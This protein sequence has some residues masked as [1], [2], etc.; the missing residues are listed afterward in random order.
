MGNAPEGSTQCEFGV[1][2][3][4][5]GNAE[6]HLRPSGGFERVLTFTGVKVTGGDA[7]VKAMKTGDLWTILFAPMAQGTIRP[8]SERLFFLAFYHFFGLE[9]IPYRIAVFLTQFAN[10]ALLSLIARRLTGS[11]LAG[12][13]APV[14]WTANSG[15]ALSMSWT[16]SWNPSSG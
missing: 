5:P 6:V 13:W 10:L 7:K 15:L 16:A 4:R 14:F 9:A 3:G 12:F 8:L 1:V 2:R 11:R